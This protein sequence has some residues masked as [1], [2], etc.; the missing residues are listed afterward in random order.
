ML[1]ASTARLVE[2][3]AALDEPESVQIKGAAEP[4]PARRLL[5]LAQHR[6]S[7]RAEANLVG[8]RWEM[9]AVEG[10]LERA[11]DGRGAVVSVVGSPGI[12]KSRLIR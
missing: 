7:Q 3:A 11:I 1:S 5:G 10:L 6:A 12:G 9:S 4:V 2:G 8:R